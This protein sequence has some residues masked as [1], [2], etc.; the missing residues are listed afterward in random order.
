LVAS[1]TNSHVPVG[2]VDVAYFRAGASACITN[3]LRISNLGTC[4]TGILI[5][6][7]HTTSIHITGS[8]TYA[9]DIETG[10]F[11]T[12]LRIAAATNGIIIGTCDTAITL[13]GN[14]TVG[15]LSNGANTIGIQVTG[16]N[17]TAGISVTGTTGA[18]SAKAISCVMATNNAAYGDGYG[19]VECDLTLTGT[20]GSHAA[21]LSSWVNITS[22]ISPAGWICA[23]TNGVY[24]DIATS[25]AGA[26]VI[27]GMRCQSLLTHAAGKSYPFSVVS[28]TNV[29]TA[30]FKC[31]AGV[32]DMGEITDIGV[33]NGTLVPLFEDDSGLHYVKIYTATP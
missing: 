33:D 6:G 21:A 7:A 16:A 28:N 29:I 10:T 3:M 1:V 31:G 26:T 4:A 13:T 5:D 17:T 25:M 27:F 19:L 24:E 15:L 8:A 23:Q 32:S 22:A 30:I 12:G 2:E 9:I 11:G 20:P 14:N 18:V